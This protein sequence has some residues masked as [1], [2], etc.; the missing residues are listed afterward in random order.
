MLF[1][2]VFLGFIA[3]NIRE[4]SVEHHRENEYIHSVCEDIQS[5]TLGSG[6]VLVKLKRTMDG[7]DSIMDALSSPD[8]SQNSN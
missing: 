2:A 1:L 6:R 7:M 5:D 4:E 8:M 3:E